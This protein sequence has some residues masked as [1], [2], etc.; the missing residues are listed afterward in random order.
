MSPGVPIAVPLVKQRRGYL[1]KGGLY[2][3]CLQIRFVS[4]IGLVKWA[5]GVSND[6]VDR[7]NEIGEIVAYGFRI[8]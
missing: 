8:H 5:K 1:R 6:N 2:V 7:A 4:G 3:R